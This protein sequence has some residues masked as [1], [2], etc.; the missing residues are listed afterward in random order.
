MGEEGERRLPNLGDQ[1]VKR[2][3]SKGY[4]LADPGGRWR[5]RGRGGSWPAVRGR[6]FASSKIC[7]NAP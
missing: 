7:L 1:T 3:V 4:S 2:L 5:G 6:G